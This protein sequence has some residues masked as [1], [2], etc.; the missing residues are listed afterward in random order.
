MAESALINNTVQ[1]SISEES[2]YIEGIAGEDTIAPG[3]LMKLNADGTY[4]RHNDADGAAEPLFAVEN[5][6]KGEG[7]E[8]LV[9]PYNTG[10][11]VLMRLCRPG[12]IL[13]AFLEA[14]QSV[15]PT[16]YLVSNGNGNLIPPTAPEPGSIIGSPVE[17]VSTGPIGTRI[18][19]YII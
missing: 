3:H 17:S 16:D 15:T 11:R 18:K 5:I 4:V 7:P 12:D 8:F 14:L 6:Y 9:Y 10:D 13:L 19:I 2:P 1:L